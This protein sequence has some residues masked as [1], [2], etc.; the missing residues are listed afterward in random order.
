MEFE[1]DTLSWFDL[2]R[3]NQDGVQDGRQDTYCQL[4]KELIAIKT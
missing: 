1:H 4:S 2:A 3:D